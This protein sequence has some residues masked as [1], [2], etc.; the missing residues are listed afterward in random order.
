MV[1]AIPWRCNLVG[2]S[3]DVGVVPGSDPARRVGASRRDEPPPVT[4]PPRDEPPPATAPSRRERPASTAAW[5][6]G[7]A[8]QELPTVRIARERVRPPY[9]K[10]ATLPDE[11]VVKAI[12]VGQ[13]AFLRCWARAQRIEGLDTT[14]VRLQLEVNAE[15]RVIQARTDSDSPMLSRCLITVARGLAFSAPDQPAVVE[16]PLM[17]R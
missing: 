11:V 9:A 8:K 3:H 14:K 17:F 5:I 10:A 2:P 7:E 13:P 1:V 15:G 6:P 16:V 12:R 4:A